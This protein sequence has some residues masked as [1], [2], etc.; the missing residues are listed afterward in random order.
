MQTKSA[1]I[2]STHVWLCV[3]GVEWGGVKQSVELWAVGG[4]TVRLAFSDGLCVT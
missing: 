3:C 2:L 1:R 4:L